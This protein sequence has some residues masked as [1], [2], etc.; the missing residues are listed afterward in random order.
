M[1]S[2]KKTHWYQEGLI[3]LIYLLLNRDLF[4]TN[5]FQV[6]S[7]CNTKWDDIITGYLRILLAKLYIFI[8]YLFHGMTKMLKNVFR[9]KTHWYQEGLIS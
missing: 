3:S 8:S 7:K 2:H 9:Q 1:F 4:Q 6:H 5:C